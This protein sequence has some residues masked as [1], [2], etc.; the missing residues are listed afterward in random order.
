MLRMAR[1]DL[2]SYW[3]HRPFWLLVALALSLL[4]SVSTTARA[5]GPGPSAGAGMV[6]AG[7]RVVELLDGIERNLVALRAQLE[8]IGVDDADP[9]RAPSLRE[10]IALNP[11]LGDGG[12][13]FR[14]R[15]MEAIVRALDRRVDGLIQAQHRAGD[16]RGLDIARLMSLDARSL[17]W[18]IEELRFAREAHL[19]EAARGRIGQALDEIARGA[20]AV[21]TLHAGV[22]PPPPPAKQAG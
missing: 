6:A 21:A 9:G 13:V 18:G 2:L 7:A 1:P 14:L 20:V 19:L 3:R 10:Q 11:G 15:T 22:A 5:A 4:L 17:Q 12:R 8:L 16:D